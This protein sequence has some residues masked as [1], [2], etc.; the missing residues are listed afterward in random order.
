[1]CINDKNDWNKQCNSHFNQDI[2]LNGS[3]WLK[4][5]GMWPVLNGFIHVW[6]TKYQFGPPHHQLI[7]LQTKTNLWHST[8]DVSDLYHE[9]SY[10]LVNRPPC[11]SHSNCNVWLR[12]ITSRF[13]FHYC[14]IAA[15]RSYIIVTLPDYMV[16][17]LIYV[18]YLVNWVRWYQWKYIRDNFMFNNTLNLVDITTKYHIITVIFRSCTHKYQ[19]P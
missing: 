14:D 17:S 18:F 8:S 2:K 15:S 4:V 19:S 12:G 1:M 9:R 13:H 3:Q 6:I 16:Y 10:I 7:Y 5:P 11:Q